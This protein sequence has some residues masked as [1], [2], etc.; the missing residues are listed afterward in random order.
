[1]SDFFLAHDVGTGKHKAVIMDLNGEIKAS[2]TREYVTYYPKPG[3]A[4]QNPE[5][6]WRKIIETTRDVI[7]KSCVE[8]GDVKGVSFSTHMIGV[9][10][11][12]KEMKPLRPAIIWLDSRAED[13]ADE[14]ISMFGVDPLL[15]LVGGVPGGKDAVSK[16]LWLKRNEGE[17]LGKAYKILDVK[18]YIIHKM[19]GKVVTDYASASVRGTFDIN[20]RRWSD[21]MAEAIGVSIDMYPELSES[22]DVIGSL[23][24]DAAED[25]GLKE[26]TNVINGSGDVPAASIGSG[27][28]KEG[29][30]HIYIGSSGWVGVMVHK[31]TMHAERGMGSICSPIPGKWLFVA[32]TESAG[33]CLNWFVENLGIQE[34]MEAEKKGKDVFQILDE[35]A[36]E[37][38]PGA[39]KLIFVPWM[40]GERSP[41][42]DVYARGGFINLSLDHKRR[43]MVRSILEGVALNF[44][45]I[46][47]G[48]LEINMEIKGLNAVGGGAKS[49]LWLQIISDVTGVE[50][51]KMSNPQE[52]SS[53]GAIIMAAVGSGE[54]KNIE[55]ASRMV[56][57]TK[58][59][60]PR[61]ELTKLYREIY[62]SFKGV[63][64]GLADIY[65]SLNS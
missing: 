53:V 55:E 11:V 47:E 8:P 19:T 28:V 56:R 44:K 34:E 20:K 14:I 33:A 43:D 23:T 18:D 59:F 62:E 35:E 27:A 15:K 17:T 42:P 4:E 52:A 32:E 7:R 12:D 61:E 22:V 38:E 39:K 51:V 9:L 1:M 10:P 54:I 65:S 63:Y 40:F 50:I 16:I 13:E 45:W 26:G 64:E 58:T 60:S 41:I 21:D 49:D 5:D 31:H 24:R 6:W 48:M 46:L 37:S 29:E 30:A 25:L 2:S 36:A 3:W 57:K